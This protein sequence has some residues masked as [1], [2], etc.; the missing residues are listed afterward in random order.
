M[1]IIHGTTYYSHTDLADTIIL[2]LKSHLK[3]LART[4]H[5]HGSL[6]IWVLSV[7]LEATIGTKHHQWFMDQACTTTKALGLDKWEDVLVRLEG[8]PLSP[9]ILIPC[10][11]LVA[12]DP[13][14]YS[15]P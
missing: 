6:G 13:T 12:S 10:R 15:G 8:I 7:G 2:Q 14:T 11:P 3:A 5:I 4:S 9:D 1:L